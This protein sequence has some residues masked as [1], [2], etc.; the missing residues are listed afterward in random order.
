[1]KRHDDSITREKNWAERLADFLL[2]SPRQTTS[3]AGERKD[4]PRGDAE[5]AQMA[6]A[7]FG[8]SSY[9]ASTSQ[10]RSEGGSR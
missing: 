2:R 4:V 5:G 6:L 9:S 7:S 3:L 8:L 1:M 10:Q